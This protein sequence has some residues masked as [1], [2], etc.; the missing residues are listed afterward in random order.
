MRA[1][2]TAAAWRVGLI[3]CLLFVPMRGA[4]AETGDPATTR[5]KLEALKQ[6]A[7]KAYEGLEH[8]RAQAKDD[9]SQKDALVQYWKESRAVA[10]KLIE[11]ADEHP[12][13]PTSLDALIYVVHGMLTGYHGEMSEEIG[14]TFDRLTDHWVASETLA[15][16]CYYAD[17][18]S[19]ASPQALRFLLAA[20]DKSPHRVVRGVAC[21]GLAQHHASRA[22]L[23][24]RMH[25]PVT[26]R[27]VEKGYPSSPEFLKGLA[28]VDP[29]LSDKKAGVYY[30]QVIARYGDVRLPSPYNRTPLGDMARGELYRMHNLAV[31]RVA[32]EIEGKDVDGRELRLSEHRGKVVAIVFWATWC[33][34]CMGMVP[35]EREIVKRLAGKPF[36][37]L[38]VNG[39]EDRENARKAAVKE[40]MSWQS[41]WDGRNPGPIALKWGVLSWPAV[42][43][44]DTQGVIRYR[45]VRFKMMDE[46]IDLL[47][48]EAEAGRKPQAAVSAR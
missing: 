21:L 22:D 1:S 19:V 30:D 37:L 27:G 29:A 17:G 15:P 3:V 14:K 41:W 8:R 12:D 10:R 40:R 11:L 13:D 47:V 7:A 26:R 23:A 24:R 6:E 31:G 35:H 28:A 25:D 4:S 2:S 20:L 39:D 9:A 32:P 38:G 34:P 45:N 16:L 48:K 46:A 36:V 5:E 18:Y 33:G 42:Y 43:I 44:L